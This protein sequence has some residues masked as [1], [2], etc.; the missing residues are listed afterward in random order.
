MT[1]IA[2]TLNGATATRTRVV[3]QLSIGLR[4]KILIHD[5]KQPASFNSGRWKHGTNPDLIF[6]SSCIS[7]LFNKTVCPPIPR[8]Q[9]RPIMCCIQPVVRAIKVPFKRRFNYTKANWE[10]LARSVDDALQNVLPT[11]QNYDQFVDIVSSMSR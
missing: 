2:G 9:H 3:R 11:P 4:R 6:V 8:T 7:S 5:P 1:L 10:M